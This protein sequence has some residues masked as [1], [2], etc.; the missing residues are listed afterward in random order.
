MH[1]H[2]SYQLFLS[3]PGVERSDVLEEHDVLRHTLNLFLHL[4]HNN[5]K[6]I[7]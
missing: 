4:G 3:T 5:S 2:N 6:L 7:E 1:S